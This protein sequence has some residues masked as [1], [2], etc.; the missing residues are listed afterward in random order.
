MSD[1]KV[2]LNPASQV[3]DP[4]KSLGA[5]VG[6][7]GSLFGRLVSWLKGSSSEGDAPVKKTSAFRSLAA[8]VENAVGGGPR[9][10]FNLIGASFRKNV[11]DKFNETRLG[12]AISSLGTYKWNV[13]GGTRR[14]GTVLGFD[15][16]TVFYGAKKETREEKA[17]RAALN[18][19]DS[20]TVRLNDAHVMVNRQ[21]G[22]IATIEAKLKEGE[23]LPEGL[24]AMK[25]KLEGVEK[26]ITALKTE[27]AEGVGQLEKTKSDAKDALDE[28]MRLVIKY[29]SSIGM[30]GR[31]EG[32]V[33]VRAAAAAGL[34]AL[35]ARVQ[36]LQELRT[37]SPPS[38]LASEAS[39]SA[40][41]ES[42]AM[43]RQKFDEVIAGARKK[44]AETT[45]DER[46]YTFT[47]GLEGPGAALVAKMNEHS[48]EVYATAISE[49]TKQAEG[50][51]G[52]LSEQLVLARDLIA[53]AERLIEPAAKQLELKKQIAARQTVAAE[54]PGT[55][56]AAFSAER[57]A[58][59]AVYARLEKSLKNTGAVAPQFENQN[60]RLKAELA[61]LKV[62]I[63]SDSTDF[64]DLG[65][66]WNE[67]I[68]QS[69]EI[70]AYVKALGVKITDLKC[71]TVWNR[72]SGFGSSVSNAASRLGEAVAKKWN[73]LANAVWRTDKGIQESQAKKAEGRE[74]AFTS[75]QQGAAKTAAALAKGLAAQAVEVG[76]ELTVQGATAQALAA[77]LKK[78]EITAVTS[79]AEAKQVVG[80]LIKEMSS[81]IL[82]QLA[83]TKEGAAVLSAGV[84]A[85]GIQFSQAGATAKRLTDI[86]RDPAKAAAL[87]KDLQTR[88]KDSEEAAVV[89]I[90]GGLSQLEELAK[91][92]ANPQLAKELVTA[93]LAVNAGG[94]METQFARI[95]NGY[96]YRQEELENIGAQAEQLQQKFL[97][98]AELA[99]AFVSRELEGM[100]A[101][102]LAALAV[103]GEGGL[104][105]LTRNAAKASK[106]PEASVKAIVDAQVKVQIARIADGPI[107]DAAKNATPR[108][109]LA[110]KD[111][112]IERKAAQL[113]EE[114]PASEPPTDSVSEGDAEKPQSLLSRAYKAV[115]PQAYAASQAAVR[116][117]EAAVERATRA[118]AEKVE[119]A[120]DS[121]VDSVRQ[122]PEVDG[123]RLEELLNQPEGRALK[124]KF[125]NGM[126]MLKAQMPP[127]G[128]T[129][130]DI[131]AHTKLVARST[132]VFTAQI[133]AEL[134]KAWKKPVV[135]EA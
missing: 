22:Q 64:D 133:V 41:S 12:K 113:L 98:R 15:M 42:S 48:K 125:Q 82:T 134:V 132:A 33:A 18:Q 129:E 16:S 50:L 123:G 29:K 13:A 47:K 56:S 31:E 81:E 103:G 45:I 119:K 85:L 79:G 111:A 24:A 32:K 2:N 77:Y 67:K 122:V 107:L 86:Q 10:L 57:E 115:A 76:T 94:D 52:P 104:R 51:Q 121:V 109:A 9:G 92:Y 114:G 99:A 87:V 95:T 3:A 89:E 53:E 30:I 112:L 14:E 6:A 4:S 63:D 38:T 73:T 7:N 55:L 26:A 135:K 21:L 116:A 39:E 78:Q 23:G 120:L 66:E 93:A 126:Y 128:A 118:L 25:G 83:G 100:S 108:Q 58:L 62:F 46:K 44:A 11:T 110:A 101:V 124:E 74:K 68:E 36:E 102:A 117:K 90:R 70:K 127:K 131:Q 91:V 61:A 27:S 65:V 106:L 105:A 54:L 75:L 37:G 19:V 96:Q 40:S 8:R 130:A 84:R 5:T 59:K 71:Q 49:V 34:A 60:R 43:N 20:S 35:Q 88:L 97:P 69:K 28:N 17:A 72:S 1:S 80:D